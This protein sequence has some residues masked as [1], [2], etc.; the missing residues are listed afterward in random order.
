MQPVPSCDPG[1]LASLVVPDRAPSPT[2]GY[3]IIAAG[4][5]R[6]LALAAA[7]AASLRLFD[8]TRPVQLVTDRPAAGLAAR[9]RGLFDVVTLLPA[10]GLAGPVVKLLAYDCAVF[11]ETMFVDADC[12]LL[13]RDIDRWWASLSAGYE[14]AVPGGWMQA[15]DWYGMDIAD[16]CALAGTSR[17]VQ[18]NSGALFF[19]RGP[20]AERMFATA[21]ALHA[22]LGNFTGHL[23]RGTG[24]PD[25]PYFALAMGLLGLEPHPL[26]DGAGNSWMTA[27]MNSLEVRIDTAAGT[28]ALVKRHRTVSPSLCHFTGL[29]PRP[30]YDRLAAELLAAAGG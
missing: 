6:Y 3:Q 28:T 7:C 11:D 5:E 24:A 26:R 23:H 16:M 9:L 15:G 29:Y 8:G 27:T 17:L 20:V 30:L 4:A 18:M 21:L 10:G 14:V 22:R 12:L 2:Q 13:K 1:P 19:R 25:E